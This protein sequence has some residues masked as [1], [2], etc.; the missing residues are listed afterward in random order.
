ML[1][2]LILMSLWGGCQSGTGP[3][4]STSAGSPSGTAASTDASARELIDIEVDP[5]GVAHIVALISPEFEGIKAAHVDSTEPATTPEFSE[6]LRLIRA[7]EAEQLLF[8]STAEPFRRYPYRWSLDGPRVQLSS[9]ILAEPRAAY[10]TDY[11]WSFRPAIDSF[12]TVDGSY[13]YLWVWSV[14]RERWIKGGDAIFRYTLSNGGTQSTLTLSVNGEP[15]T[16]LHSGGPLSGY[17]MTLGLLMAGGDLGSAGED[18]LEGAVTGTWNLTHELNGVTG[19]DGKLD[20]RML[21]TRNLAAVPRNFDPA[22]GETTTLQGDVMAL[23][24]TTELFPNGWDPTGN[25]DWR[26]QVL[27]PFTFQ[28]MRTFTGTASVSA[29]DAQGKVAHF[30]QVWDG[31]DGTGAPLS[32]PFAVT[33]LAI[34]PVDAIGNART[35]E[36]FNYVSVGPQVLTVESLTAD[37]AEFTP[38]DGETTV[39]SGEIRAENVTGVVSSMTIKDSNGSTVRRF[40]SRSGLSVYEVWDGL[41]DSGGL[42]GAGTYTCEVSA[43]CTQGVS[44]TARATV[45]V[46]PPY[47]S[48][49]RIEFLQAQSHVDDQ[50][51][52]Y[53]NA[54]VYFET[55]RDGQVTHHPVLIT[56]D[57]IS[58]AAVVSNEVRTRRVNVGAGVTVRFDFTLK[59]SRSSAA[60]AVYEVQIL[61]S[62][63]KML[64][65]P[66]TIIFPPGQ[67]VTLTV[68]LPFD[69]LKPVVQALEF[70]KVEYRV[71]VLQE[72]WTRDVHTLEDPI[73]IGLRDAVGPF[74]KG[75]QGKG[76]S[77]GLLDIACFLADGAKDDAEVRNLALDK[78]CDWLIE[79]EF[80]YNPVET[81]S[82]VTLIDNREWAPSKGISFEYGRFMMGFNDP[83][84][85]WQGTCESVS[86]L[87]ALSC[88]AL[89]VQ[90]GIRRTTGQ[91]RR[92]SGLNYSFDSFTTQPIK[93]CAIGVGDPDI[94]AQLPPAVFESWKFSLHQVAAVEGKVWDPTF[95][96]GSAGSPAKANG[97]DATSFF[98]LILDPQSPPSEQHP[99]TQIGEVVW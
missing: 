99:E 13:S 96:L 78:M 97:M 54:G 81:H 42:V 91:R 59:R 89:G 16:E 30:E 66:E 25:L 21:R 64:S 41:N 14:W 72:A 36:Q 18:Y 29:H 86:A 15:T 98:G 55:G 82:Y 38:D 8:Q 71:P 3:D 52:V 6:L 70:V 43:S 57:M 49:S 85:F 77:D 61:D 74:E 94:F 39:L 83:G 62:E 95:M 23:P 12:P 50:G 65:G 33:N 63:A 19:E 79:K 73:Y 84:L 46:K 88:N 1:L 9:V 44:H 17:S 69:G 26:I 40:P 7:D 31:K 56:T 4:T 80:V 10:L 22:V 93:A 75:K 90:M 53:R 11:A 48:I 32:G 51:S 28:V 45:V 24:V 67:D 58:S 68:D 37:P 35:R 27:K 60:A 76:P 5:E 87:Y 20:L 34:A 47:P 2:W 92:I